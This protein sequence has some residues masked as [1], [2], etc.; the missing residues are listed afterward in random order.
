[1]YYCLLIFLPAHRASVH[2]RTIGKAA[3]KQARTLE[4]AFRLAPRPGVEYRHGRGPRN[5]RYLSTEEWYV[6]SIK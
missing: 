3:T 1:M 6:S 4:L 5:S 2:G